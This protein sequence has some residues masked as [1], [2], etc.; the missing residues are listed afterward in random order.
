M[1]KKLETALTK[2]RSGSRVTQRSFTVLFETTVQPSRLIVRYNR[3]SLCFL[4]PRTS[5]S[6]L[7]EF[8]SRTFSSHPLPYVWNTGFHGGQFWGFTMFHLNVQLCV[9]RIAVKVNLMLPA[10]QEVK[11][12]VK[13]IEVL[14]RS[15]EKH[16]HLRMM[17]ATVILGTFNA[18]EMFW[19]PSPGLCRDTI[20]SRS[21]TDNPFDLIAWFLLWHAL[22]TVGPYIDRCAPFQSMSN[23][24]TL[25]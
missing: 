23:Q 21:S 19:Y 6:V 25:A 18:A 5:I 1:E 3:R 22:S 4:G 7:S 20:L 2:E 24:L 12:I 9:I 15:L 17:D 16:R 13:T 10:H 8:K 14:K 11:Y